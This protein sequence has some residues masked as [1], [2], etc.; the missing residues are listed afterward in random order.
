MR[1]TRH[2]IRFVRRWMLVFAALAI[3]DSD[4]WPWPSWA[5]GGDLRRSEVP[6]HRSRDDGRPHR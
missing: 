4:A 3:R 6:Q 5:F 2:Q 1:A